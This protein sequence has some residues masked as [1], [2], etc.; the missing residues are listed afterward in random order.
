MTFGS[1]TGQDWSVGV[2]VIEVLVVVVEAALKRQ[3]K[4]TYGVVDHATRTSRVEG[5]KCYVI[6]R[7]PLPAD[8]SL[9]EYLTRTVVDGDLR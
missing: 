7:G 1:Y 3:K 6:A 4:P 9:F 2:R 5:T 8:T